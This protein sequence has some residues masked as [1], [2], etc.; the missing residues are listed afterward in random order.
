MITE[1]LQDSDV[2]QNDQT[3]EGV[4]RMKQKNSELNHKVSY[5]YVK[6]F[7][8]IIKFSIIF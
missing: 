3:Q 8:S 7:M 1:T 5:I 2:V 4:V 6:I